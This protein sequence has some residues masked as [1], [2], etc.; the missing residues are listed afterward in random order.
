ML[1]GVLYGFIFW[2]IGVWVA[3]KYEMGTAARIAICVGIYFL[4]FFA[5]FILLYSLTGR[6]IGSEASFAAVMAAGAYFYATRKK[7]TDEK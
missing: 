6:E 1:I 3:R 2:K 5:H 7:P 4:T